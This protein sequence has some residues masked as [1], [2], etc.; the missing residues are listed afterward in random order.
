VP[1]QQAAQHLQILRAVSGARHV[2]G[3]VSVDHRCPAALKCKYKAITGQNK[4]ENKSRAGAVRVGGMMHG[5][6]PRQLILS[7]RE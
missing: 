6:L 4:V 5:I 7:F 1:V 3:A 2:Q